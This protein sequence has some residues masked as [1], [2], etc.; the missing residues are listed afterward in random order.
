M[1]GT[2]S[3]S[4]SVDEVRSTEQCVYCKLDVKDDEPSIACDK[5]SGWAHVKCSKLP[6]AALDI[7]SGQGC[8]WFC[9]RCRGTVK[10]ILKDVVEPLTST[11]ISE[12]LTSIKKSIE[13]L[14]D[15]SKLIY[16]LST[17]ISSEKR[18]ETTCHE[19]EV[20]ISGLDEYK[21]EPNVKSPMSK[22]IEFETKKIEPF[23]FLGEA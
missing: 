2:R 23:D 17:N 11:K 18:S 9:T 5:C 15:K 16:T 7:M 20:R 4:T 19:K 14:K 22:I 1:V 10:R 6:E 21:S 12:C 13:D 3:N 8:F